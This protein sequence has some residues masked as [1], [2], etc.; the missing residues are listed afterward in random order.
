MGAMEKERPATDRL[1]IE[2]ELHRRLEAAAALHKQALEESR[3]RRREPPGRPDR[4]SRIM[5][6]EQ[7]HSHAIDAYV[8]ALKHF[9]SFILQ[10]TIPDDL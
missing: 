3:R 1:Q 5:E 7:A 8:V 10:G 2:A 9:S 4:A 6:A